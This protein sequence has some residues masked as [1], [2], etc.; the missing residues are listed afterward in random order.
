MSGE[1]CP[2]QV[3]IMVG[4]GRGVEKLKCAREGREVV[5]PDFYIV[6]TGSLQEGGLSSGPP[7]CCLMGLLVFVRSWESA[8]CFDVWSTW[9]LVPCGAVV[10]GSL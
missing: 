7:C 2:H 6:T 8:S 9:D 5:V 10:A 1:T 4:W 3:A